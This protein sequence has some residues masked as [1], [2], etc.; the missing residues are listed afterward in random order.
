MFRRDV[1]HYCSHFHSN[2]LLFK[3][4]VVC[5]T[6]FRIISYHNIFTRVAQ[7]MIINV[8]K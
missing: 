5:Q 2:T 4:S 6:Y 1:G 7:D 3:D 8:F